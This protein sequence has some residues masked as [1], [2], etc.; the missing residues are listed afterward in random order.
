MPPLQVGLVL[1]VV[2]VTVVVGKLYIPTAKPEKP[3]VN[4][5]VNVTSALKAPRVAGLLSIV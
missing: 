3:F 2:W 4:E 5:D 1:T